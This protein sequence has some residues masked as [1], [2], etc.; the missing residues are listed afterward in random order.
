MSA[1][2]KRLYLFHAFNGIAICIVGSNLFRDRLFLYLDLNM[3]QF[4]AIGGAAPFVALTVV[5]LI[6][7]LLTRVRLD[8]QVVATCYLFRVAAPFLFLVVPMFT[9]DKGV[10]TACF[11]GVFTL[12]LVFPFIGQNSLS[13]LFRRV[14]DEGELGRHMSNITLLWAVPGQLLAVPCSWLVDRAA[15]A[16]EREFFAAYFFIFMATAV[17]QLP[18]SWVMWRVSKSNEGDDPPPRVTLHDIFEPMKHPRF[19]VLLT[20]VFSLSVLATMVKTFS[21]PYLMRAQG[22]T[23]A[24]ISVIDA[25]MAAVA[26]GVAMMWGRLADRFG[27]RNVARLCVFG[28][29]VGVLMMTGTGWVFVIAYAL[30]V[31]H[32]HGGLFGRGTGICMQILT[33]SQA[34]AD[35]THLY[36]A[37][38][39]FIGGCGVLVGSVGGGA[40]LDWLE[41]RMHPDMPF[42]RYRI[43]F[44][45]VGLAFLLLGG[46]MTAVRDGRRHLPRRMIAAAALRS[47][48]QRIERSIGI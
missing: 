11:T 22:L 48:R 33:L 41:P 16:G 18:A 44:A 27:A 6:S 1:D 3:S 9:R 8:P 19:R 40:I 7:P 4:G 42:E 25:V 14:I 26:M 37:A 17:F 21:Y 20:V 2:L 23:M 35:R 36:V 46:L 31:W 13:A 30:L 10:M 5:L 24:Q 39:G 34:R 28:A 38:A 43:Y 12:S 15:A 47:V 29:A 32:G 45:F